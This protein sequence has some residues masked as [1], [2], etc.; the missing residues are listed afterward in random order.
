MET[1]QRAL[2]LKATMEKKLSVPTQEKIS[3]VIKNIREKQGHDQAEA[4]AK[5]IRLM[6][7]SANS[8]AEFLSEFYQMK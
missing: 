3:Q 2:L 4:K 5:E 1:H 7:E 8:E 6:L